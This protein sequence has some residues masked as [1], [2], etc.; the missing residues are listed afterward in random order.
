MKYTVS[1]T[2]LSELMGLREEVPMINAKV[3]ILDDDLQINDIAYVSKRTLY[4]DD[5]TKGSI[6]I[7]NE[8]LASAIA[9]SFDTI[10]TRITQIADYMEQHSAI[11]ERA[12]AINANGT[13]PTENLS[14]V[15]NIQ[16]HLI[17][18]PK[19]LWHVDENGAF[20]FESLFGDSALMLSGEGLFL[21]NDWID[22]DWNWEPVL[23]GGGLNADAISYGYFGG[24]TLDDPTWSSMKFSEK[25]ATWITQTDRTIEMH[26]EEIDDNSSIL[27]QAGLQLD[28][29][30]ILIYADDVQNGIGSR[31]LQT[32][33]Q[34]RADV[35]DAANGLHA[36]IMV[37]A[38]SLHTEVADAQNGLYSEISQTANSIYAEVRDSVN[39]LYTEI[40]QT[41]S[42]ISSQ[43]T[44]L[45]TSMHSQILQ[46]ASQIR[47]EVS[48]D[49]NGLASAIT[50]QANRISLVVEGTGDNAHIR[51]A[52]IV[53]AINNQTGQSTQYLSAD[54]I[55]LSG[56]VTLDSKMGV[57]ENG[58][59]LLNG[60]VS[61]NGPLTAQG[62]NDISARTF[63]VGTGGHIRLIGTSSGEYYDLSTTNVPNAI[64]DLRFVEGNNSL[65]TLQ[66]KT[67]YN[68][69]SWTNAAN[70]N[71]AS[72]QWYAGRV[73]A[74][75][76]AV[77]DALA[78]AN[79][80]GTNATVISLTLD[81]TNGRIAVNNASANVMYPGD[82]A[83]TP[84]SISLPAYLDVSTTLNAYATQQQG[85]GRDSI[86]LKKGAWN[87][88][89]VTIS[90]TTE[91]GYGQTS[92]IQLSL[93]G[94]W[95]GN[96]YSYTV[97]DGE[98]ST[99]CTGTITYTGNYT[100][101]WNATGYDNV[102]Y[103]NNLS[104]SD[105][106]SS[107]YS[108]HLYLTSYNGGD[109]VV[110]REGSDSG[111]IVAKLNTSFSLNSNWSGSGDT[112]TYTVS[113]PNNTSRSNTL[114]YS[115]SSVNGGTL[116]T[117]TSSDKPNNSLVFQ[118]TISDRYSTGYS[119]GYAAC[120]N[121][122]D[123][124]WYDTNGGAWRS[125]GGDSWDHY[126]DLN[127]QYVYA[128]YYDESGVHQVKS[129]RK[130]CANPSVYNDGYSAGQASVTPTGAKY[131]SSTHQGWGN[132][133]I[134]V[135][136]NGTWYEL[137]CYG[138]PAS[139]Y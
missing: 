70:F 42:S 31:I 12:K 117:V 111:T 17:E 77:H 135:Q 116:V 130:I 10:L 79:F 54:K 3:H 64:T 30:G 98:G 106:S 99:G 124:E 91:V 18:S 88:G 101:S 21:A 89:Q 53:M 52:E 122:I 87:G 132:F 62:N 100:G 23:D 114:T 13:I 123:L 40:E 110:L 82:S 9:R 48:D 15:I 76:D 105:G 80:S 139:G 29:N 35:S 2:M 84:V 109:A 93:D 134:K 19:S 33:N 126:V 22:G 63:T 27:R 92:T 60:T 41:A 127:G 50:Q 97:K 11:Y 128:N 95:S 5:P 6:E 46:T 43:V 67:I 61:V 121:T 133:Y 85:I 8:D 57:D 81:T 28:A 51:P 56:Q 75:K 103:E 24:V 112:Q 108:N 25:F 49:V 37:T 74:F 39:G 16:E 94:S 129:S 78:D 47:A 32:A 59:I 136:V 118:H 68:S 113:G 14:G 137:T 58:Y 55:H 71:M 4:L 73:E 66:K 115:E 83:V 45:S 138:V 38:E 131:N 86:H 65:M 20:V 107:V 34:I 44:D 125:L 72:T 104:V 102:G 96:Q 69:S 120:I 36:E 26:A 90:K 119:D 7:S 1:L